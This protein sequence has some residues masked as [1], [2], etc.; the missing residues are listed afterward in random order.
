MEESRWVPFPTAQQTNLPVCSPHRSFN[1]ERQAG[2]LWIPTTKS[3]VWLSTAPET[4]VL[5]IRPFLLSPTFW[6][7]E[8]IPRLS[9]GGYTF[10]LFTGSRVVWGS[11]T[12]RRRSTRVAGNYH[13]WTFFKKMGSF[14]GYPCVIRCQGLCFR[15][16]RLWGHNHRWG[17]Y[18][19]IS[20][21]MTYQTISLQE[22][23]ETTKL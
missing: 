21:L 11:F 13:L 18:C 3:L 17:S 20:C 9:V 7:C 16:A 2:K 5:T 14:R 6:P 4:D 1:A 22:E 23:F 12:K 15:F 19:V 10:Y 8:A